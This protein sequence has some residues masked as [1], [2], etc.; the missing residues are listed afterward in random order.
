MQ[1]VPPARSSSYNM[2]SSM[3]DYGNHQGIRLAE[4]SSSVISSQRAF[5]SGPQSYSEVGPSG[6]LPGSFSEADFAYALQRPGVVPMGDSVC[7]SVDLSVTGQGSNYQQFSQ[8]TSFPMVGS[9]GS[10]R[11]AHHNRRRSLT[12]SNTMPASAAMSS[13]SFDEGGT[14]AAITTDSR[15]L[16][17]ALYSSSQGNVLESGAFPGSANG[18]TSHGLSSLPANMVPVPPAPGMTQQQQPMEDPMAAYGNAQAYLQ[19][20]HA[21]LRQQQ[22]LLQQQQAAL[23]LQQQQLQAYGMNPA[24]FSPNGANNASGEL[25]PSGVGGGGYYYVAAAADG[26]SMLMAANSGQLMGQMMPGQMQGQMPDQMPGQMA[27]VMGP[28]PGGMGQGIPGMAGMAGMMLPPGGMAQAPGMMMNMPR[29]NNT[30]GNPMSPG[31]HY[32]NNYPQQQ[33]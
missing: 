9:Y 15:Q 20:Q 32:S 1:G 11:V 23:A 17:H 30:G 25:N 27:N 18:S 26:T 14:T 28:M 22:L 13:R 19:Q 31:G 10:N 16:H 21:A 33:P 2:S 4:D 6:I 5:V 3:T 24:L 12:G 7:S 29:N 8:H